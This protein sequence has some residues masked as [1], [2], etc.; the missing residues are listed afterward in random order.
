MALLKVIEVLA[1]SFQ[2]LGRCGATGCNHG[3]ENGAQYQVDLYR[4]LRGDRR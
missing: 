2:K 4:K 3:V 1:D